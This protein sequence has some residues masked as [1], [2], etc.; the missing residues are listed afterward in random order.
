MPESGTRIDTQASQIIGGDRLLKIDS[1]MFMDV[2]PL[3]EWAFKGRDAIE[4]TI[5]GSKDMHSITTNLATPV[6]VLRP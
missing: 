6:T 5:W 4:I 2:P 3:V 1:L